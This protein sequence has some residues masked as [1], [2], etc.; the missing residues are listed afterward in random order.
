[1]GAESAWRGFRGGGLVFR[2]RCVRQVCATSHDGRS[3]VHVC[4]GVRQVVSS[5]NMP[6]D[7]SSGIWVWS[8][9]GKF[10]R[11]GETNVCGYFGC[12]RSWPSGI[13]VSLRSDDS[14]LSASNAQLRRAARVLWR[15]LGGRDFDRNRACYCAVHGRDDALSVRVV[16]QVAYKDG[17]GWCCRN[18]HRVDPIDVNR[19]ST[20]SNVL[21]NPPRRKRR[22]TR[23]VDVSRLEGNSTLQLKTA[24]GSCDEKVIAG[25]VVRCGDSCRVVCGLPPAICQKLH[26]HNLSVRF[27]QE[28]SLTAHTGH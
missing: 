2:Q 22:P 28:C 23:S 4:F 16:S 9:M 17:Y 15:D 19:Q 7:M 3:D 18:R 5:G 6:A 24:Y 13:F 25:F 12:P 20:Q 27:A 11:R 10:R 8:C 21:H 1:M 14:A 26:L